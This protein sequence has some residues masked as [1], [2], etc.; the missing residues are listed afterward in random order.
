MILFS[1]SCSNKA[2]DI[3]KSARENFSVSA[4]EN[5]QSNNRASAIS[6]SNY[7][8]ADT[9]SNEI[10][11][12]SLTIN[13]KK[14][15]AVLYGNAAAE[16]LSEH[17][18]MELTMQEL[19]ENEKYCNLPYSLPTETYAPGTIKAGDIMLWQDNCLVLFY[20][21]FSTSYRY[22]PVGYIE[23]ADEL[24]NAV[25]SGNITITIEK[26]YNR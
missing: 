19:N 8:T 23:N 25:G 10:I 7:E 4:E 18:P 21:S 24:A 2:P 20:D 14:F 13:G 16:A 15:S 9:N 5:V 6:E 22:T 26:E 17:L 1:A 3:S 11:K 12:L